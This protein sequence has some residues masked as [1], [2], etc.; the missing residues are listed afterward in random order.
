MVR[1]RMDIN[2]GE[3]QPDWRGR[4][5]KRF[6]WS[7]FSFEWGRLCYCT[8]CCGDTTDLWWEWENK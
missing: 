2:S 7:T 3:L 1:K 5:E 6:K 8:N 4:I